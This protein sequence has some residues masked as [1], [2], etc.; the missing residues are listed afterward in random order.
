[1]V[2]VCLG[3]PLPPAITA[4]AI[5][6]TELRLQWVEPFTWPDHEVL[7]YDI[8]QRVAEG[9]PSNFNTTLLN[10]TF[11]SP[12]RVTMDECQNVTFTVSAVSDLGPSE[13]SIVPTGLPASKY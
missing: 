7:H 12:S 4:S 5:S 6:A 11:F 10:H 9:T 8:T 13:P 3:A 2:S 1:M